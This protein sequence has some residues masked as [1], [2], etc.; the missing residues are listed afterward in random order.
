MNRDKMDYSVVSLMQEDNPIAVYRKAKGINGVVEVKVYNSL[1]DEIEDV[2]LRGNPNDLDCDT[3]L[4]ELWSEKE[5]VFFKRANKWH[6]NE[7]YII[8]WDKGRPKQIKKSANNMTDDQLAELVRKPFLALR[9][10][11]NE[12]TTPAALM[13]VIAAAEEAEK[14]EKTMQFLREKLSLLQYPKEQEDV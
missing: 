4:V 5:H 13:R 11:V 12:M 3:C 1:T 6:L 9:N 14:P 2:Q 7:G 10:K 8:P